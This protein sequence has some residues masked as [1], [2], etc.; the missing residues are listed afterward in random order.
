MRFPECVNHITWDID[1]M[2]FNNDFQDWLMNSIKFTGDTV[3]N[4]FDYNIK[5]TE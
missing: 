3:L 4:H 5:Y 2:V 1:G